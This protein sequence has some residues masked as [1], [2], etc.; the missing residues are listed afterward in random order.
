MNSETT[1][2]KK[3]Y[4]VKNLTKTLIS[5][6][7]WVAQVKTYF[8]VTGYS[9]HMDTPIWKKAMNLRECRFVDFVLGSMTIST[10]RSCENRRIC[11]ERPSGRK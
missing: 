1:S 10:R 2:Q 9:V 3:N 7:S 8:Q 4:L 6:K 11:R 5:E